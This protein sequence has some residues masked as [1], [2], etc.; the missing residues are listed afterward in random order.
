MVEDL[1]SLCVTPNE[2]DSDVGEDGEEDE[3]EELCH[4]VILNENSEIFEV[5]E[6]DEKNLS[7]FLSFFK[8]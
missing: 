6:L 5:S 4:D 1:T 3:D 7:Y 8:T 2:I